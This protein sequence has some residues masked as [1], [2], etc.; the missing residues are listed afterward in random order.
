M[1][2]GSQTEAKP[3]R[4]TPAVFHSYPACWL[5]LLIFSGMFAFWSENQHGHVLRHFRY[6]TINCDS[7]SFYKCMH[8]ENNQLKLCSTV[9]T[10]S[11]TLCARRTITIQIGILVRLTHSLNEA[12]PKWVCWFWISVKT[13]HTCS[14]TIKDSVDQTDDMAVG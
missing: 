3:K 10:I 9:P 2:C 11:T 4:T 8:S 14:Y 6:S 1:N 7:Q 5:V 12:L 13:Q